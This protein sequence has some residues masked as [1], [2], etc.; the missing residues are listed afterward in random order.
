MV[1]WTTPDGGHAINPN[2]VGFGIDAVTEFAG[3]DPA[4]SA[5]IP[6]PGNGQFEFVVG[7]FNTG[8]EQLLAVNVKDYVLKL[9]LVDEWVDLHC[10]SDLVPEGYRWR[11]RLA[12]GAF[13]KS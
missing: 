13:R 11:D 2:Y 1:P 8:S 9:W 12:C 3:L 10:R 4:D 5:T 6:S 7:S